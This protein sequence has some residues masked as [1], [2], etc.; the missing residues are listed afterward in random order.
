[1]IIKIENYE[2]EIGRNAS[3]NWNILDFSDPTD[4]L[5]HLTCFPSPYVLLKTSEIPPMNIILECAEIC[6][7]YSKYKKIY[8]LKVDYSL[9]SNILKGDNVGEF[10]YISNRKVK[11]VT[12]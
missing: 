10:S 8:P 4:I 12:V 3:E 2:V 11:H 7:R 1:M 5:F 6:K 9:C